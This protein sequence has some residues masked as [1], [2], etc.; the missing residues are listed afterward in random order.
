MKKT[1]KGWAVIPYP[2]E[3]DDEPIT[4][5]IGAGS[6][7]I[8]FDKKSAGKIWRDEKIVEVEITIKEN[9]EKK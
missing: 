5:V 9:D 4:E 2:A 6:M 7:A 8:Y 3:K 1:I